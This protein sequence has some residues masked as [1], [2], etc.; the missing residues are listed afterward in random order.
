[1]LPSYS[2]LRQRING[3]T[4]IELLIVIAII[5]ILAAILF[6]VFS[7]V[8]ESARRTSCTSN[9]KQIGI[10]LV[11]YADDNDEHLVSFIS[12]PPAYGPSDAVTNS[13]WMDAVYPFLKSEQVFDCP[14]HSYPAAPGYY[15]STG[16]YKFRS[17]S[18]YGSY[19]INDFYRDYADPIHHSPPVSL[20]DNPRTLSQFDAASTTVWVMDGDSY[21]ISCQDL[22]TY[23]T[24]VVISGAVNELL[25]EYGDHLIE[26]HLGTLNVL[27]CDG[28]VKATHLAQLTKTNSQ[29]IMP[30]FTLED[31]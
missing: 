2:R 29:G 5:A 1:M 9:L 30:A 22:S 6:P 26:R 23:P 18:N 12:P 3:F 25:D 15:M 14:D 16:D 28:H 21:W 4:L 7:K 27:Y 8:R 24:P 19:A 11:Q 31:D 10:A 13:K 20:S 17:G